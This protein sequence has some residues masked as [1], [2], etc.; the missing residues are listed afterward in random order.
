MN[1]E[2]NIQ[3][4]FGTLHLLKKLQTLQP[5][6]IK[7]PSACNLNKPMLQFLCDNFDGEIHMSFGMT[8]KDEEEESFLS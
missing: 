1:S 3:H 4:L 5:S 2:L 6:L 8:T 7:I